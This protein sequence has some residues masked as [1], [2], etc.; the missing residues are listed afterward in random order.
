M[1]A[2]GI[3][4]IVMLSGCPP[5]D[6]QSGTWKTYQNP[7]YGFEFLYPSNWVPAP[8]PDNRDGQAFSDRQNLAVQILGS[9]GD[10]LPEIEVVPSQEKHPKSTQQNFTTQQGRTGKLQVDV[11]TDFSLMTLTLT[12]GRIRYTWQGKA[13]SKQFADYYRFFYYIAS[14]Y[15]LP[16]P[17]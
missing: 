14:Q 4:L 7:R 1:L 11:G 8:M 13:P 3:A 17:K 12:Q 5:S 16:P 6:S 2:Y 9:A 15:R 10:R